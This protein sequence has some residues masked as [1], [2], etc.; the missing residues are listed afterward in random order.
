MGIASLQLA[1][2][3]AFALSSVAFAMVLLAVPLT[4]STINQTWAELDR[5]MNQFQVTFRVRS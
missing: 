1:S 3:T 5:E 2:W 4:F